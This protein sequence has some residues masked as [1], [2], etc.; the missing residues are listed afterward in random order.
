MRLDTSLSTII[1]FYRSSTLYDILIIDCHRS[2]P[3]QLP[4]VIYYR[5]PFYVELFLYATIYYSYL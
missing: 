1:R 2:L 4:A 3:I 5:V